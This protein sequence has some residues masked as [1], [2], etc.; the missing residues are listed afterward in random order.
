MVGVEQLS[1]GQHREANRAMDR[2]RRVEGH[3]QGWSRSIPI[4][5]SLAL[6]PPT[7]PSTTNWQTLVIIIVIIIG[8]LLGPYELLLVLQRVWEQ[9][10][11][12]RIA[13][14]EDVRPKKLP[15][16]EDD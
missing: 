1:D 11:R 16:D 15:W 6:L 7:Q 4:T 8:V 13:R 2:C 12:D 10:R 14:G 9:R 5:T 3:E